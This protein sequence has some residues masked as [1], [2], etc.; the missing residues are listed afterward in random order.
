MKLAP[1][2][3]RYCASRVLAVSTLGKYISLRIPWPSVNHT[4]DAADSEVPI[5]CL[6]LDVQLGVEPGSPNASPLLIVCFRQAEQF[7]RSQLTF[8]FRR[9]LALSGGA[10]RKHSQGKGVQRKAAPMQ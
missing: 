4:G 7:C 8:T 9:S 1:S 6:A 5:P 3:T 10:R 2:V